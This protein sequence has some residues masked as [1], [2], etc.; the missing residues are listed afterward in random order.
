MK[1]Q[2]DKKEKEITERNLL[3]RKEELKDLFETIEMRKLLTNIIIPYNRRME[4]KRN[5]QELKI[6][7]EKMEE[8]QNIINITE[9]QLKEGIE[10]KKPI[11]VE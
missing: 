2:Y 5:D 11:G 1:R 7:Q 8:T 3:R 9:K 10:I 6:W 4:D